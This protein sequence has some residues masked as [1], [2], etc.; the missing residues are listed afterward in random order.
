MVNNSTSTSATS[1]IISTSST[2]SNDKEF[3]RYWTISYIKVT[4]TRKSMNGL[5][6]I[7]TYSTTSCFCGCGELSDLVADYY[8]T[9]TTIT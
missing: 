6:T 4:R 5:T 2:T 3:C 1:I 8:D 9:G 7:I